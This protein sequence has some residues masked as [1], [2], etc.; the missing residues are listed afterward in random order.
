MPVF[1]GLP[2]IRASIESLINQTYSDWECVIVDDGSTDG[3]SSYLDSLSDSRFL[4][5]H[6]SS[7]KGRP[8]ARQKTL[9]LCCGEYLAFL[10]AGDLYA[11]NTLETMLRYMDDNHEAALVSSSICSFGTYTDTVRTRGV[12]ALAL[13]S[14]NG[15]LYPNFAAS[16]LRAE[17]AKKF[18]FN[19]QM[20]L[21]EDRDY[22]EKYLTGQQFLEIPE[23]LYY[24]SEFDSV[25][26]KKILKSYV[27]EIKK[28]LANGSKSLVLKNCIKYCCSLM[29]YPF[30]TTEYII[31]R[32]GKRLTESEM[33]NYEKDCKNIVNV[34][35]SNH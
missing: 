8:V 13:Q 12:P 31:S 23:I 30:M 28:N 20:S 27:F 34:I 15:L 14:F 33:S 17:R 4:V 19:P 32:R 9:E 25:T 21:G 5:H 7:N 3:T 26:K 29:I 11:K 2:L 24:Y 6:F 22:L 18:S 16:M 1:N 10:D 35:L